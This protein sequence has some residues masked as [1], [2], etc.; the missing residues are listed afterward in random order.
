VT[1]DNALLSSLQLSASVETTSKMGG[2]PTS[3]RS[4]YAPTN[5]TKTCRPASMM[6]TPERAA[7]PPHKC[8]QGYTNFEGGTRS[9]L[10][11]YIYPVKL[12][13]TLRDYR[14]GRVARAPRAEC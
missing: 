4:D 13:R 8:P 3:K 1:P 7:E 5:Q 2:P 9:V 11:F 12:E 10:F 14:R 6:K